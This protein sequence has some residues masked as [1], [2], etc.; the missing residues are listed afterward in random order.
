MPAEETQHA[1]EAVCNLAASE[2]RP[3]LN[4]VSGMITVGVVAVNDGF[5]EMIRGRPPGS[6]G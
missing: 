1:G 5:Q 3:A 6:L 4:L 2:V